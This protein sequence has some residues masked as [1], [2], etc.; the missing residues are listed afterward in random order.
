MGRRLISVGSSRLRRASSRSDSPTFD[1]GIVTATVAEVERG[2]TAA[3]GEAAAEGK[4]AAPGSSGIDRIS[5][6]VE[7]PEVDGTN[8]WAETDSGGA[9]ED[10]R[11][12]VGSGIGCSDG[13]E[14]GIG[15]SQAAG[16]SLGVDI[17][18]GGGQLGG[19]QKRGGGG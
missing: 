6:A 13:A 8:S 17:T 12:V 1:K 5:A 2:E 18:L 19:G 16:R 9:C 10:A 4:E 11:T 3:K 15:I 14:M 7:W